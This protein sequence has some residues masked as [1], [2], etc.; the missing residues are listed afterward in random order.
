MS[1]EKISVA[2][3]QRLTL[4][5]Q[6]EQVKKLWKNNNTEKRIVEVSEQ[7]PGQFSIRLKAM[8]KKESDSK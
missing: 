3:D 4:D 8:T 7:G 1:R 6:L 2:L 5:E